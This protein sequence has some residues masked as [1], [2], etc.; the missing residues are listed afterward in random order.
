MIMIQKCFESMKNESGFKVIKSDTDVGRRFGNSRNE[1]Y[2][3]TSTKVDDI[4][5]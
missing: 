2:G 3:P 4:Q 1:I 5:D